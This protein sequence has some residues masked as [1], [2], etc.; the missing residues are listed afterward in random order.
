[1]AHASTDTLA[2]RVMDRTDLDQAI[3]WAAAEAL[4]MLIASRLPIQQGS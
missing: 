2:I 4:R 3:D 1:M